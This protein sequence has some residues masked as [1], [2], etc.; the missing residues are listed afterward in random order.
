MQDKRFWS[1]NI[2]FCFNDFR[3]Q[4]LKLHKE[5]VQISNSQC[6]T[7]N[8]LQLHAS[9]IERNALLLKAD[10]TSLKNLKARQLDGLVDYYGKLSAAHLKELTAELVFLV[11]RINDNNFETLEVSVK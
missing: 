2:L 10:V 1:L 7:A 5:I 3:L 8:M 9:N 11:E 4:L 6:A